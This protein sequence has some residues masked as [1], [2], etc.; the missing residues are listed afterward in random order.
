MLDS[1]R[2]IR[3]ALF[4]SVRLERE[5]LAQVLADAG[6][7]VT[8][9]Y[10][11]IDLLS[12]AVELAAPDAVVLDARRGDPRAQGLALALCGRRPGMRV[13]VLSSESRELIPDGEPEQLDGNEAGCAMLVGK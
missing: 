13:L 4:G 10:S 5:G 9:E 1:P 2:P 8:G 3:V 7:E 12:A 6:I 11:E